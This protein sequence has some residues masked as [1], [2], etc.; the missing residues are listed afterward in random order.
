M[1]D[2]IECGFKHERAVCGHRGES[3][4]GKFVDGRVIVDSYCGVESTQDDRTTPIEIINILIIVS[5]VISG[6]T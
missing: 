5:C 2:E 4:L 1:S 3:E 6:Y